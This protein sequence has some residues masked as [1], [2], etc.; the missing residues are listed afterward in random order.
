MYSKTFALDNYFMH[1]P[2]RV[3]DQGRLFLGE[4]QDF[5]LKRDAKGYWLIKWNVNDHVETEIMI[6]RKNVKAYSCDCEAFTNS[7]MCL[8]VASALQHILETLERERSEKKELRRTTVAGPAVLSVKKIVDKLSAKELRQFIISQ[9]KRNSLIAG[10]LRA[11]FSHKVEVQDDG[12]YLKLIRSY[13]SALSQGRLTKQKFGKLESFLEN[14]IGH[15]EDLCSDRNYR[16]AFLILLGVMG[17]L[18]RAVQSYKSYGWEDVSLKAHVFL[19]TLFKEDLPVTFRRDAIEKLRGIYIEDPYVILDPEYNLFHQLY[20]LSKVNKGLIFEDLT[21]YTEADPEDRIALFTAIRLAIAGQDADFLKKV[22]NRYA[23]SFV[24]LNQL[25][26]YVDEIGGLAIKKEMAYYIY[27]NSIGPKLKRW[28]FERA[29]ALELDVKEKIEMYIEYIVSSHREEVIDELQEVAGEEWDSVFQRLIGKIKESPD[30]EVLLVEA[31]V[32]NDER[33]ELASVVQKIENTD[34]LLKHASY[35]SSVDKGLLLTRLR[36]IIVSHLES[37]I[38]HQ[39]ADE[40]MKIFAAL[41]RENLRVEVD[42]LFKVI[43]REF[44]ERKYLIK[45]LKE[46]I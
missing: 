42:Y 18:G 37:H 32:K 13:A 5:E 36:E 11:Q 33:G 23:Q 34:L 21:K 10:E 9:S 41:E 6:G 7:Q 43:L 26:L 46:E 35:L 3:L 4:Q 15:G 44:P 30:S 2:E 22:I 29:I 31:L 17:Y 27:Q 45:Y 12:K 40:V 24:V 14:L 28:S 1:I 39:S 20:H 19:D 8:H 16:E 25:A 38:G